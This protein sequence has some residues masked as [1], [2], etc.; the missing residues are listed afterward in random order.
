MLQK[1]AGE[2]LSLNFT[3]ITAQRKEDPPVEGALGYPPENDLFT[4]LNFPYFFIFFQVRFISKFRGTDFQLRVSREKTLQGCSYDCFRNWKKRCSD[5]EELRP[6]CRHEE[7]RTNWQLFVK[8]IPKK[9][10]Q[11]DVSKCQQQIIYFTLHTCEYQGQAN[12]TFF[13]STLVF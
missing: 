11:H 1:K 10:C 8:K 3:I 13:W 6:K 5:H 12:G 4:W 9:R 7:M 2:T